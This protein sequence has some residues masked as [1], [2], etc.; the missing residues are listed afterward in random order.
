MQIDFAQLTG[1]SAPPLRCWTERVKIHEALWDPLQALM[2]VAEEEGFALQV[3]SGHRDYA[4]QLLIWN[5]KVQ[6]LRPIYDEQGQLL[7]PQDYGPEELLFKILHW[8]ALPGAS[9]HHWGT[10]I[11]VFDEHLV[12]TEDLQLT[13]EEAD[14]V[15]KPFHEWLDF[16]L[17]HSPFFRPYA[18]TKN[19]FAREPWHLSYAPLAKTYQRSY[20]LKVLQENIAQATQLLLKDQVN[21]NLEKIFQDYLQDINQPIIRD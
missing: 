4:R 6:G 5:E 7:D 3:A 9:R 15:L 17:P 13:E 18:T 12:S 14:T 10:E 16:Y 20:T 11:D 19:G 21:A 2:A 1:R 8:N